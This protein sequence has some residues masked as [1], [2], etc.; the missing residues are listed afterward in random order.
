MTSG[1]VIETHDLGRRAG[2]AKTV[3]RSAPAPEGIGTEVIG[4][5]PESDIDLDLHIQSVVEGILVSGVATVSV[6]GECARCLGAVTDEVTVDLQELYLHPDQDTDDE[7][8]LRVQNE[9]V[10]LEPVLR[11]A[12]VLDLP[13]T[14]LCRPDCAGL[15]PKCGTDLNAEPDHEHEDDIDARWAGLTNWS[16]ESN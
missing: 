6:R 8:A 13:F 11:D 10:D 4:V 16:A 15:C 1:L 12:V 14:P 7:E 9:L 5:P 2:A 3:K